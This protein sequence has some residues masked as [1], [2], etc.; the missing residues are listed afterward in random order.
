MLKKLLYNRFMLRHDTKLANGIRL[1]TVPMP[2]LESATLTVWVKTGSRYEDKSVAGI[3]HFLEH[4]TFKGSS[5]YPT[6]RDI[7]ETVESLG[8]EYNA[9]TAH[10]YTNFYIKVPVT[11]IPKAFEILSDMVTTP[12][13][14]EEEIEKERGVILEEMAMQ[15]DNPMDRIGDLFSETIF[16]ENPLGRDIA[17]YPETVKKI[18]KD[19]FLRYIKSHYYTDNI[20]ITVAGGIKEGE[21]RELSEKYFGGIQKGN[22]QSFEKFVSKQK[23][24]NIKVEYK[25]TEQAHLILGFHSFERGH[26]LRFAETLLSAILGKGMSSRLFLEIREKRGLAYTVHTSSSRYEDIGLFATYAGVDVKKADEAIKILLEQTYGLRDGKFPISEFEL[27]K[28]KQFM[29][30]RIALALED[31]VAVNE[32][33]GQRAI[34]QTKIETPEDVFDAID[35]V[36]V[37]DILEVAKTIFKKERLSLAL[38]GPYKNEKDFVKLLQ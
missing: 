37:E 18:S 3:S 28:A 20:I 15:K 5:K 7:S 16:P 8:A 35:K 13:L 29:K 38:I 33:F 30:G 1:V 26:K 21:V 14:P 25:A 10:D 11:H 32:F 17:G 4:M 2:T 12:R 34:Y 31:T 24:P 23:K 6:A 27:K 36:T 22:S 19:D 9:G